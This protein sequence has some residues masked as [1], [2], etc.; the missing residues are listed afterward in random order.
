MT[1]CD[2]GWARCRETT[3]LGDRVVLAWDD[4]RVDIQRFWVDNGSVDVRLAFP[5]L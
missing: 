2:G 1:S 3:A 5:F 4:G